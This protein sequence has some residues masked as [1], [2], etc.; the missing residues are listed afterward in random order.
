MKRI[1]VAINLPGQIKNQLSELEEDIKGLFPTEVRA[2]V[3]KWVEPENLHITLAFL[4]FIKE[5]RLPDIISRVKKIA[6]IV[7]PFKVALKRVCYDSQEK[8][9]RLIWICLEK[10]DLLEKMAGELGNFNFSGHITLSRIKGW[11]WKGIE[12]EERP[13]IER[14]L[15]LKIDVCSIELMESHLTRKGPE[16]TILQSFPLLG[17]D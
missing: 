9:P 8:I 17:V 12:P 2:A 10:N 5:E 14:G 11:V 13:D 16:Y 6:E 4:G 1:F 15:D 3:S 7:R